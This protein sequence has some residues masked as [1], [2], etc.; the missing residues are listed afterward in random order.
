MG[1]VSAAAP[2]GLTRCPWCKFRVARDGL[3][4]CAHCHG[5]AFVDPP[6]QAAKMIHV[7]RS[8]GSSGVTVAYVCT[9]LGIAAGSPEAEAAAR[10]VAM[11][12]LSVHRVGD[13]LAYTWAGP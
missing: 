13:S 3:P 6:E 12:P 11:M 5:Y 10:I 8:A 2:E 7:V 9:T 1:L 4:P